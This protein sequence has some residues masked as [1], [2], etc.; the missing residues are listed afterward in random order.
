MNERRGRRNGKGRM[1]EIRGLSGK[2]NAGERWK[3]TNGKWQ[4]W[5][6]VQDDECRGLNRR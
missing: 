1:R 4:L 2:K 3:G 6:R 5:S